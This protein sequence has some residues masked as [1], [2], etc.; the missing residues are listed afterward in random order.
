MSDDSKEE[1]ITAKEFDGCGWGCFVA[2]IAA[3]VVASFYAIIWIWR[4]A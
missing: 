2:L 4:H 3:I 1:I